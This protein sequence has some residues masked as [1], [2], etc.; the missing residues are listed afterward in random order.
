MFLF[1]ENNFGGQLLKMQRTNRGN[2]RRPVGNVRFQ[3]PNFN[4]QNE[5]SRTQR[6]Q[7]YLAQARA[8]IRARQE[9]QSQSRGRG[10]FNRR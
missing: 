6:N 7:Q 2:N 4:G 8:L 5:N 3:R 10:R 1:L 9:I